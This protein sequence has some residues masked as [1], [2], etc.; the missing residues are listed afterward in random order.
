MDVATDSVCFPSI[1]LLWF[2][3]SGGDQSE[4]RR[5]ASGGKVIVS[6]GWSVQRRY[7]QGM[8]TS[9]DI[10]LLYDDD[11]PYYRSF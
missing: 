4:V 10:H 8:V 6:S 7:Y 1:T 11:Y 5:I 2:W 9:N 3:H